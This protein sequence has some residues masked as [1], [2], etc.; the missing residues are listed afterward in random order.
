MKNNNIINYFC[1]GDQC[2]FM[3]IAMPRVKHGIDLTENIISP[4]LAYSSMGSIFQVVKAALYHRM[5]YIHT[6]LFEYYDLKEL[7]Q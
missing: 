1:M 2:F 4:T 5:K 6:R 3:D 7:P